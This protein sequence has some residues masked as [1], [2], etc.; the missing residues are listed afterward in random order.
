ANQKRLQATG[1]GDAGGQG[2]SQEEEAGDY[3]NAEYYDIGNDNEKTEHCRIDNRNNA[4]YTGN[5]GRR[6]GDLPD[7]VH[8]EQEID[9]TTRQKK[10]TTTAGRSTTSTSTKRPTTASTAAAKTTKAPV[11]TTTTKRRR[12]CKKKMAFDSNVLRP[13]DVVEVKRV[14]QNEPY[15]EP[16]KKSLLPGRRGLPLRKGD[17]LVRIDLSRLPEGSRV[18]EIK[19]S[20]D[21][22][23]RI[24]KVS[25][26]EVTN[27]ERT[28]VGKAEQPGDEPLSRDDLE[29]IPLTPT[30]RTPDLIE[31]RIRRGSKRPVRVTLEVKVCLKKKPATTTTQSTTTSATTTRRPSTAGLTTETTRTTRGTPAGEKVTF[32][33]PSITSRKS[34]GRTTRQKKSTTTAGRSTTS[35]STK[36]PTTASTAAAK[37]TKAPV[38]TTTTKR[39]RVCKKKM[40]FDSNVL[41][42][43]DVVEVKRVPQNEPY[44]EPEKKSLLPGRRGL[45]LRKGDTLVR[46]DLSRLPEGSRV[47]EIKVSA[48]KPK[49]ITKVSVTEVT[50]NERTPVGKAEQ[51]GDEPLSR[52]D[53]ESIPLTPT[54]RTPDLIEGDAGGQGVSQ[55]EAGDYNNAEYYD[56]GNDNEKTEHCRIDNRNNAHYTGHT[57]RR[58]EEV[59]NN[60]WQIDNEHV[61]ETANDGEHCG[62]AKTTKA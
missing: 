41:R 49:R 13:E 12:V 23:K 62:R 51:P 47:A 18:A 34:T 31:V 50:N 16:E 1:Q 27:N 30:R 43:E 33:M 3:N 42:P 7:A 14:P 56:I 37:T 17:T 32:P 5:T 58:K 60:G 48:D 10:S 24:T 15:D 25:V 11:L 54:R 6:K 39:R 20:A 19:V 52:D 9:R 35:T 46:I 44:D 53:L 40:A 4:H 36:R 26:T 22:P 61:D 8:H 45:P 2:V 21:K 57:G 38:L 59:D 55:E 28:P 29:S